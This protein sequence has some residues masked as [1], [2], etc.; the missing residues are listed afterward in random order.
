MMVLK[1]T[2]HGIKQTYA[3]RVIL[4]TNYTPAIVTKRSAIEF[5]FSMYFPFA[6]IEL[7]GTMNLHE[8]KFKVFEHCTHPSHDIK[9]NY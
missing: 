7:Q 8:Y 9:G 6:R 2:S 5:I 3:N 4:T 1:P